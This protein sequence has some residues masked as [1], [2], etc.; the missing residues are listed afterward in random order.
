[1]VHQEG[2]L[3]L[4]EVVLQLELSHTLSSLHLIRSLV[5]MV[6]F[7]AGLEQLLVILARVKRCGRHLPLLLVQISQ[8]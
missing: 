8:R 4:V 3:Q 5:Q 6:I 7:E 1:M 2:E